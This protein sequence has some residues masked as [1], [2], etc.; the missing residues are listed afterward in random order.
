MRGGRI[1]A[2]DFS[3]SNA[4]IR[5]ESAH[6]WI[7]HATSHLEHHHKVTLCELQHPSKSS[8]LCDIVCD[9]FLVRMGYFERC[10]LA[11]NLKYFGSGLKFTWIR[12]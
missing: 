5:I 12:T 11:T 10:S 2:I 9:K 3:T 7:E 6:I 4:P 1:A 8:S